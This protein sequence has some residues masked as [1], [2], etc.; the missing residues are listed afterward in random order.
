MFS[1][2]K[3]KLTDWLALAHGD[4][5]RFILVIAAASFADSIFN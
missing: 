4:L 3:T 5:G 2:Q 1:K